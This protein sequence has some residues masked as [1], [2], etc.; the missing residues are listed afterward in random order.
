MAGLDLINTS[1]PLQVGATGSN[2]IA[3]PGVAAPAECSGESGQSADA[4]IAGAAPCAVSPRSV[5]RG[6]STGINGTGETSVSLDWLSFSFS[7]ETPWDKLPGSSD[8]LRI[9]GAWV[10]CPSLRWEMGMGRWQYYPHWAKFVI[11]SKDGDAEVGR[12]GWG[13]QSQKDRIHVSLS[14]EGCHRITDWG[15]VAAGIAALDGALRRVDIAFDDLEG[16]Y[17]VDLAVTWYR[18]DRFTV[19]GRRPS[20]NVAGDWLQI[21]GTGRTFYVGKRASGKMLR[22]YEKGKQLGDAESAWVRWECEYL[23]T[24]RILPLAILYVPAIYL[25]GSYPCLSFVSEGGAERIKT[26]Q[27]KAHELTLAQSVAYC[28]RTHGKLINYLLMVHGG[29]AGEVVHQIVRPGFPSRFG[30][31]AKGD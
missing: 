7:P 14:G 22:V 17:S 31:P 24:S 20:Y 29:D 15:A 1:V 6:E 30:R 4:R 18:E 13:G 16:Q 12:I 26:A 10:D 25:A 19:G 23:S 11:P 5:I 8:I 28:Q 27:Q 2:D 21:S 9:V 3:V